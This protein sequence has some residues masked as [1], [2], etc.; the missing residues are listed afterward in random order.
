MKEKYLL[1]IRYT[2][3]FFV[4]SPPHQVTPSI[5]AA[6]FTPRL[7]PEPS[8][9]S[10]IYLVSSLSRSSDQCSR[11]DT[12]HRSSS[13]ALLHYHSTDNCRCRGGDS[14]TRNRETGVSLSE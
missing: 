11:L 7:A 4:W 14:D 2:W 1:S 9:G 3:M 6:Q 12:S 10:V 8:A 5:I 13:P